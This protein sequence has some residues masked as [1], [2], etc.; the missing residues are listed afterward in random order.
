VT[1]HKAFIG[2]LNPG[3]LFECTHS[4]GAHWGWGV[5]VS[6]QTKDKGKGQPG[7]TVVDVLL[8]CAPPKLVITQTG[9]E[10]EVGDKNED[11]TPATDEGTK[12]Y[13]IVQLGLERIKRASGVRVFVPQDLRPLDARKALGKTLQE[14]C[15]F[16]RSRDLFLSIMF[17]DMMLAPL[18]KA[19][20][21]TRRQ[22]KKFV[23]LQPKLVRR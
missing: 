22:C 11:H 6:F 15:C 20:H 9:Q 4:S 12:V 3:R 17:L 16:S 13:Q 19:S 1:A 21:Y 7:R 14:V 23:C 5:L 18:S 2:F 10:I 8:P